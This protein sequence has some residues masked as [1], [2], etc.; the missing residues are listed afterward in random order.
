MHREQTLPKVQAQRNQRFEDEER[1]TPPTSLC[2]STMRLSI[3]QSPSI[4]RL[5]EATKALQSWRVCKSPPKKHT[6]RTQHRGIDFINP[7]RTP[8]SS[9]AVPLF[10]LRTAAGISP[11]GASQES[12]GCPPG[13]RY[14]FIFKP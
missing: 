1:V 12:L 10:A 4:C 3:G 13:N 2:R 14:D 7:E 11:T 8:S 5:T 9:T 6:H